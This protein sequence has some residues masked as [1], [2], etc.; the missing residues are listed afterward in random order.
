MYLISLSLESIQYDKYTYMSKANGINIKLIIIWVYTY[1]SKKW[2]IYF[3]YDLGK[4]DDK[5]LDKIITIII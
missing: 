3:K 5:F 4:M 1:L 2:I